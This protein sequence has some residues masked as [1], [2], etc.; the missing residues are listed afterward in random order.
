VK[1]WSATWLIAGVTA[2]SAQG[3]DLSKIERTIAKEPL[4]ETKPRYCLLAF[5]P[6]AKSLV[7]L[8]LDGDVL[9]VDR[10]GNGDLTEK[11]EW[12]KERP[13]S[14]KTNGFRIDELSLPED[15]FPLNSSGLEVSRSTEPGAG[16]DSMRFVITINQK[17]W[18][19]TCKAFADRPKDAPIIHFNFNG[20]LTFVCVDPPTFTAGRTAKLVIHIG[21]PGFGEKTCVWR[22]HASSIV[23]LQVGLIADI[24]YPNKDPAGKPILARHILPLEI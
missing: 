17:T 7:W 4:Y 10:N 8:V 24:E 9:Y 16:A 11:G 21:T 23:G 1:S 15:C 12:I 22:S 19:A 2:L 6:Q 3:A 5:G 13:G 18:L 14:H 20:P